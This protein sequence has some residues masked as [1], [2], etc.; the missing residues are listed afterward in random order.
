MGDV[1]GAT[2]DR[3]FY[4]PTQ[5]SVTHGW[6]MGTYRSFV[7]PIV[8]QPG[9]HIDVLTFSQAKKILFKGKNAVGVSVD[10]FGETLNYRAK[11]EVIVSGGA[12]GSP[13]LLLLSGVGPKAHLKD[14]GIPLVADLP[15]GEN[16]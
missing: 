15:V 7:E 8:G 10:R 2:E 12:I 5:M 9:V 1:N 3:G 13:Q 6:R 14:Q 16:L 4:D 11:N